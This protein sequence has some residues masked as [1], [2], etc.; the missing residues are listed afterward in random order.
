MDG[1]GTVDVPSPGDSTSGTSTDA[2]SDAT[3]LA[4]PSDFDP[5]SLTTQQRPLSPGSIDVL[6][7][8]LRYIGVHLLINPLINSNY[9]VS[10]LP[11]LPLLSF[12]PLHLRDEQNRNL[13]LTSPVPH[14]RLQQQALGLMDLDR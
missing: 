11:L 12:L 1:N 8:L 14:L 4:T 13:T 2:P 9:T 10:P 5:D 7:T 3:T 6:G